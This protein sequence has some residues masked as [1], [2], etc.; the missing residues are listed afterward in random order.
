MTATTTITPPDYA[1]IAYKITHALRNVGIEDV[2]AQYRADADGLKDGFV[3]LDTKN[4]RV[5]NRGELFE[6]LNYHTRSKVSLSPELLQ[7]Q[8]I[9]VDSFKKFVIEERTEYFSNNYDAAIVSQE[10]AVRGP[11]TQLLENGSARET[12]AKLK[13]LN[14]D[15]K[16]TDMK[17]VVKALNNIA[18]LEGMDNVHFQ[19]EK[20]TGQVSYYSDPAEPIE[21]LHGKVSGLLRKIVAQDSRYGDG[22]KLSDY[23]HNPGH[24][25]ASMMDAYAPDRH[26]I[27]FD[28][29]TDYSPANLVDLIENAQIALIA[30]KHLNFKKLTVTNS[31]EFTNQFAPNRGLV[32]DGID[33]YDFDNW[34]VTSVR[35]GHI[36]EFNQMGAIPNLTVQDPPQYYPSAKNPMFVIGTNHVSGRSE[37]DMVSDINELRGAIPIEY[38]PDP[39]PQASKTPKPVQK[40][41]PKPE[42][43]QNEPAAKLQVGIPTR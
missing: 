10:T 12:M 15:L 16:D 21:V 26:V 36:G 39:E 5:L 27:S 25:I 1:E 30:K 29:R 4:K 24:S 34:N 13:P 32:Q 38:S 40:T 8:I 41:K 11:F 3:F 14:L 42:Q 9:W 7:G 35:K 2:V 28:R 23:P 18:K 6:K 19:L 22:E 20:G 17:G 31:E 43:K 37:V 33:R